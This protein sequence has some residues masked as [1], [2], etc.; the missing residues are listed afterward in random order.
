MYV[1][2]FAFIMWNFKAAVG[3]GQRDSLAESFK[4]VIALRN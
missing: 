1:P 2:I 3:R 4:M